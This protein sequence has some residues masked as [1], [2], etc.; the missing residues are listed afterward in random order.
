MEFLK[1]LQILYL[2]LGIVSKITQAITG[3]GNTLFA[4]EVLDTEG[5]EIFYNLV[6]AGFKRS[7]FDKWMESRTK[8]GSNEILPK[9]SGLLKS[10]KTDLGLV[11][12]K[13][14]PETLFEP[15]I[16]GRFNLTYRT[17]KKLIE[18]FKDNYA[19][20]KESF[21]KIKSDGI[22]KNDDENSDGSDRQADGTKHT[23]KHGKSFNN[24]F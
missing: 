10:I 8:K 22:D 18:I 12:N 19:K 15:V 6:L 7:V 23:P 9:I 5:R 16:S 20:K 3:R 24:I 4:L 21:S 1:D 13:N 11:Y 14:I 17:A 2:H